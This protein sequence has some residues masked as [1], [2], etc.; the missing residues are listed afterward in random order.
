MKTIVHANFCRVCI[1]GGICL[2]ILFG[3][4]IENPFLVFLLI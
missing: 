4:N 3:G 1:S 2:N